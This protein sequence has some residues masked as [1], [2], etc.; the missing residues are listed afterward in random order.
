MK[1]KQFL[2]GSPWSFEGEKSCLPLQGVIRSRAEITR[3][4]SSEDERGD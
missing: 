3:E 4:R 1:A 2:G